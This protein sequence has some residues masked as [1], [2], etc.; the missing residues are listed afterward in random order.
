[1]IIDEFRQ[2]KCKRTDGGTYQ[3][4]PGGDHAL[5]NGLGPLFLLIEG[6]S[7][8]MFVVKPIRGTRK[9]VNPSVAFVCEK[10]MNLCKS[11]S[12]PSE[13]KL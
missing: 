4:D 2:R 3:K 7:P 12:G 10:S 8:S 1:M 9:M 5:E 11:R 6:P 13:V